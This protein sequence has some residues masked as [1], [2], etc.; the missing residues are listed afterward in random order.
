VEAAEEIPREIPKPVVRRSPGAALVPTGD[1]GPVRLEPDLA[2]IR[3]LRKYGGDD[4]KKCMQ[5][6]TC[7]ATCDLSPDHEPFPRKELAWASWGLKDRLLR[8]PDVWLCHQCNDCSTRCPRSARPGNVLA[9]VRRE[10]VLH[11]AFPGFLGRW[12]NEPQWLPLLLGIPIALL[13]LALVWKDPIENA[14]GISRQAGGRILYNYS[15]LFPHWMLNTF[16]GFFSLLALVA[17]LVGVM[18]FWRAMRAAVP[19]DRSAESGRGVVPSILTTVR[20]IFIHDDF[21]QCTRASPRFLSHLCVFFG[22]LALTLV[23]LWVITARYNPLIRGEFIYPFAFFSPWKM[24]ANVGGIALV[25]GLLLM[26]RDRLRDRADLGMGTYFDWV[27][28]SSLLL[29]VI[30]G[31]VTE[32]LHY[33]RLEPHRHVAYFAHLVFVFAVLMYLP[34]SKLAHLAYRATAMVFAEHTGRRVAAAPSAASN[35]R[36]RGQEGEDDAGVTATAP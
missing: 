15:S 32:V 29:V 17:I 5:C 25:A 31:F 1:G 6:G 18:R 36:V 16:F 9:A 35:A 14:L 34:Y 27:L 33:L 19:R 10:G 7:S 8:D 21:V 23:T 22:F 11:Y 28:I 30:T 24:L 26:A 4:Y 3:A 13:T 20:K 2:F 12:V